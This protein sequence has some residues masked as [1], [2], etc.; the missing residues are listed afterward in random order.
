MAA[1][2]PV[3]RPEFREALTSLG[4]AIGNMRRLGLTPPILVDGL[5]I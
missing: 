2:D 4:R 5:R 3:F 1:V